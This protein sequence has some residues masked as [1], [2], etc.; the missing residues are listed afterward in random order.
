LFG[1]TQKKLPTLIYAPDIMP[2]ILGLS[3]IK[4]PN[5]VKGID[6]SSVLKGT[7]KNKVKQTLIAFYKRRKFVVR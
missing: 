6:F 5:T 1:K 2:T 3:Q 7:M 4:I